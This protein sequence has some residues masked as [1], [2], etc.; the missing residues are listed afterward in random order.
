[1]SEE[2]NILVLRFSAMG[3]VAMTSPVLS[4]VCARYPEVRFTY[5]TNP[6]FKPFFQPYGNLT[7]R[8]TDFKGKHKGFGGIVALFRE[9]RKEKRYDAVVD[10]HDVLRSKVLRFLFRITGTKTVRIDKGRMQKKA[11]IR[12]KNKQLHPLRSTVERYAD[13]FAAAG[14][15]VTLPSGIENIKR[16]V[17][18]AVLSLSGQKQGKWIG[19]APFAKHK[20]KVYP[21]ELMREVIEGLCAV[22]GHRVFIFGGGAEEKRIA[23]DFQQ[24]CDHC[25]S[26]IGLLTLSQELDLISNLDCMV[27]MDS[28]AMHM[29]SLMGVRAVSVW[30]ATHPYAGFLGFGQHLDD[31]VQCDLDCRPCSVYGNKPCYKKSYE[32]L[33]KLPAERIVGKV[34]E[35]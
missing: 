26:V 33:T 13:V 2:R 20:G 4:E 19:I 35:N 25:F 27:T 18:Q 28:S 8:E 1:M 32:C 10:L 30:G 7:F 21:L 23:G 16:P 6:F 17:P 9:L 12:K 31:A 11:L 3:D 15:P 14:L 22:P 29:A 34:L 5:V 24:Q